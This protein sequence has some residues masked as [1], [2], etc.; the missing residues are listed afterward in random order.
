[1]LGPQL[2]EVLLPVVILPPEDVFI[3]DVFIPE[4]N[5]KANATH[6]ISHMEVQQTGLS[7]HTAV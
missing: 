7:L 4:N 5:S 6:W 1:M 3:P 2:M